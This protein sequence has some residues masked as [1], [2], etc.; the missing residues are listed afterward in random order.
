[1]HETCLMLVQDSQ[2]MADLKV[3][4]E[5][6]GQTYETDTSGQFVCHLQESEN[7]IHV[8][9]DEVWVHKEIS[10]DFTNSIHV[11]DLSPTGQ[12]GGGFLLDEIERLG[13]RYAFQRVLGRGGM[14][15]VMLADD[16]LLNRKVA[17]KMLTEEY[18]DE[19]DVQ[20]IFLKE[21]QSLAALSHPNLVSIYDV[22]TIEAKA[23]IVFE[24]V[25][26]VNAEDIL[27]E[28]G[29]LPPRDVVR[30]GIQLCRALEYLHKLEFI[31]RDLKPSNL[32]IQP[33]GTVRIIDFGLARSLEQI[34]ARG[35][36]V[37]GTP[38]YMAPEQLESNEINT[39]TDIYQLGVTLYELLT[40]ELP[41]DS[42]NIYSAIFSEPDPIKGHLPGVDV[43]LASLVMKCLSK[44]PTTRPSA[45][46]LV[47]ALQV[48]H[49][50][51]DISGLGT[52]NLGV[53][54]TSQLLEGQ[55]K[56][57][58]PVV[59]TDRRPSAG[60]LF[61][62]GGVLVCVALVWWMFTPP[63]SDAPESQQ[64][65]PGT[66]T[67]NVA[68]ESPKNTPKAVQKKETI[69]PENPVQ[70]NAT[71]Q[72]VLRQ[73]PSEKAPAE[74]PSDPTTKTGIPAAI[75]ENEPSVL[76]PKTNPKTATQR[77]SKRAKLDA[78]AAASEPSAAKQ[79]RASEDTP[80]A[81]P[82]EDMAEIA[83]GAATETKEQP[84][85][86]ALQVDNQPA[87]SAATAKE[88][89]AATEKESKKAKKTSAKTVE[90][91]R[92]PL[93]TRDETEKEETYV[94]AAF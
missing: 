40:G 12:A 67:V 52:G 80:E 89:A 64:E 36:R 74:A 81:T 82:K 53:A 20:Q 18:R 30:M 19:P 10:V 16:I 41:F 32:I 31:H 43:A 92:K 69:I 23:M 35:T 26:G 94:P 37:R 38:A 75:T 63:P 24:Y 21:A 83:I 14:G 5:G 87:G 56:R 50:D 27:D 70:N 44:D 79:D 90:K 46:E 62:A 55:S 15:V 91:S 1:M 7:H 22:T 47:R 45:G 42:T 33:D 2:P 66:A 58:G 48:I 86:T 9:I 65:V 88:S 8:W 71:N 84:S 34:N 6:H 78:Q 72:A 49:G 25:A 11:I 76:Q 4:I 85:G 61:V 13:S 93:K 68:A 17:I 39:A 77:A 73:E 51:S 29:A 54:T 60:S 3:R 59:P 28:E 57:F